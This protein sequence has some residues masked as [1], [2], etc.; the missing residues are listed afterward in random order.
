M[1]KFLK[2]GIT[3]ATIAGILSMGSIV[4][5]AEQRPSAA[6][7]AI[8]GSSTASPARAVSKPV[9]TSGSYKIDRD[10]TI[11]GSASLPKEHVVSFIKSAAPGAK[12]NCSVE[13]IVD[14]YYNEA[15]KEGIRGDVA[16]AQALVETGFFKY[17]G[18]VNY[19]QNNFCGLGTTSSAVRGASFPTP[20]IGVRAHIQH[21]L[22]YSSKK[23]PTERI[24]DPRFDSAKRL[25]HIYG[26]S[27]TWMDLS[28]RW[29]TDK[30]YGPKILD[31]YARMND[32]AVKN[33]YKN[34]AD[35]P[36]PSTN[37]PPKGKKTL[38][39]RIDDILRSN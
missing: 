16:L 30:G 5:A 15:A 21:L 31:V 34:S 11:A 3:A 17:G 2:L 12:L 10:L 4:F 32:H 27:K 36:K 38:Q 19:R 28:G 37:K 1:K 39:D 9:Q 35:K 33:G 23:S 26:T 8:K 6:Q 24:V 20:E 25:P 13:K 7:I 14:H 18:S 22:V 29:A